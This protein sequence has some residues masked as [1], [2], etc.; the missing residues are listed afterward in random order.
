LALCYVA[1]LLLDSDIPKTAPAA[2]IWAVSQ[3]R[4]KNVWFKSEWQ[5]ACIIVTNTHMPEQLES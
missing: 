3:K 4:N 1:V 5:W 2:W